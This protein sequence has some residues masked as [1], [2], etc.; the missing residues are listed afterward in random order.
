MKTYLENWKIHNN[1]W[2]SLAIEINNKWIFK[3]PRK[4]ENKKWL[5]KEILF[6]KQFAKKSNLPVPDVKFEGNNFYGYPKIQGQPLT[7]KIFKTLDKKTKEKIAKQLANFL[8]TL[9]KFD[10]KWKE[11][12][13]TRLDLDQKELKPNIKKTLPLLS[14]KTRKNVEKFFADFWGNKKNFDFPQALI[15]GDLSSDHIF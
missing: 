3:F 6:A 4:P 9:H 12:P 11:K 1:G 2:C 15:H 14:T 8:N 7:E 13:E 5:E 10:F